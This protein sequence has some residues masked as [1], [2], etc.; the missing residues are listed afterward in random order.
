MDISETDRALVVAEQRQERIAEV[1]GE[2]RY[3]SFTGCCPCGFEFD[4]RDDHDTHVAAAVLAIL[5]SDDTP[6]EK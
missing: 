1:L 4:F 3:S 6:K 5:D 2:H